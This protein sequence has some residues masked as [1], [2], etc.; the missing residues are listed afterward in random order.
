MKLTIARGP[1]LQDAPYNGKYWVGFVGK[2]MG[3]TLSQGNF[4]HF[5][6]TQVEEKG[7]VH[8]M[9]AVSDKK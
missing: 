3:R 6:L 5:M 4:A 8:K 2:E 1:M 7:W 9:P